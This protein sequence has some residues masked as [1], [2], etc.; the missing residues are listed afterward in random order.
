MI[1]GKRII[2]GLDIREILLQKD[3]HIRVEA[4]AVRYG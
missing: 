2:A 3:G 1:G 4:S